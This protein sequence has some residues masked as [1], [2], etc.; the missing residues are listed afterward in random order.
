MSRTPKTN[1]FRRRADSPLCSHSLLISPN[2]P[3]GSRPTGGSSQ[4]EGM[5]LTVIFNNLYAMPAP[6]RGGLIGFKKALFAPTPSSNRVLRTEVNSPPVDDAN[7]NG[8]GC[9]AHKIGKRPVRFKLC[10]L[11]IVERI[12]EVCER[13]VGDS[14]LGRSGLIC[15]HHV[16]VIQS[17]VLLVAGIEA[18]DRDSPEIWRCAEP[19]EASDIQRSSAR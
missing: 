14:G 15:L 13:I 4:A 7:Q 11:R 6:A 1:S 3:Y 10:G 18:R 12:A 5:L 2:L 17:E 16:S 19:G 9:S 8:F